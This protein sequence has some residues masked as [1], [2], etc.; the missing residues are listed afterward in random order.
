LKVTGFALTGMHATLEC[1]AC[2]INN[3]FKGTPAA[4]YGCHQ[5]E[6]VAAANPP[7]A[8]GG[9][10]HDCAMCHTTAT[11]LGAKFDHSAFTN[12][13]LTGMH[14]NLQCTQCH[15][16]N[17]FAGTPVDCYSC[18]KADFNSTTN[19]NHVASGL[20]TDCSICHS[21]SGWIPSSFNHSKTTF[22]L[23]G[24]HVTTACSTCHVNNNYTT[25]PVD[26]FGC[27][28]ADYTKTTNPNHASAGFPTDCSVCHSTTSWA[29][30]VFDHS[31]TPFPL[32]GAHITVACAQC[33]I[34]GVYAATPTDCYSCHRTDYNGTTNPNH[35]TAGFP[36]TCATCHTTTTWAGATF[37]HTWFNT[38]H[39]GANGIC[40]TCHTN[41]AD[42][43]V[44][45]CT[46]CHAKAATDQRHGGVSGYIYN[47]V[48]CYACHKNGN[49]G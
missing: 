30:A 38:G 19:P 8:Q 34:N 25:L 32:T 35:T 3:R 13:P 47:S 1:T 15:L 27:H 22:P 43:S 2:H 37:N 16:N 9:F 31:K 4:C 24:A 29:G 11:W 45:T 21:T 42:Y 33:H 46:N 20:P 26:C 23:T 5:K 39:G 41:S 48:N 18:H 17:K 40:A 49:G 7:H 28:K 6:F 10:P 12:Y 14:L 36:T 44:F